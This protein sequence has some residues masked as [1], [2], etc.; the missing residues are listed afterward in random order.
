MKVV[1]FN[2]IL[3]GL[4][5]RQSTDY[6]IFTIQ[7]EVQQLEL[8]PNAHESQGSTNVNMLHHLHQ[9]FYG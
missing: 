5:N 7:L 3:F 8:Y 6:H 4:N 2:Q 9:W 1:I